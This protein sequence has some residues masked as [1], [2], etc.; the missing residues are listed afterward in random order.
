MINYYQII[1]NTNIQQIA[2][3]KTLQN[4]TK[5]AITFMLMILE[6]YKYAQNS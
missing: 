4:I 2:K 3:I 1:E 5:M 6:Q